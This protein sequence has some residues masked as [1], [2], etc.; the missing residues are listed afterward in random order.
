MKPNLNT[1]IERS[2]KKHG[3]V[4][5]Y[6]QV[7]YKNTIEPVT[8][9]CQ[10]HGKFEQAPYSHWRGSGCPKCRY[11]NETCGRIK[12]TEQF[13]K[14]ANEIHGQV[15]DYTK[16]EY[17][18]AKEKVTIICPKHGEFQQSPLNHL[19]N[20]QGC[21]KCR[22]SIGE[23]IIRKWLDE[24]K[25]SYSEQKTFDGCRNPIT[26]YP[27]RFDFY[28]P[29]LNTLIEYDGKQHF[30]VGYFGEHHKTEKDLIDTQYRDKIKT[31]YAEKNGFRL[32]RIPFQKQM[33]INK[34]L[35]GKICGR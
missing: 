34:I 21:P 2:E 35:E 18:I 19:M 25:I 15:Y 31:E 6:S 7:K 3:K 14:D 27:L 4:Y 24:N 5:D 13:V 26:N 1:F 30:E 12:S 33:N 23:R 32:L 11:L 22:S 17:K 16:T 20:R 8:I 28:I 29:T 10:K 9:L